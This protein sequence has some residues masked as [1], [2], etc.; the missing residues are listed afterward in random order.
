MK[1][2]VST[3][4]A[5]KIDDFTGFIG[6]AEDCEGDIWLCFKQGAC[7]VFDDSSFDLHDKEEI[8]KLHGPFTKFTG[9]V[10]ISN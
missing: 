1:V 4:T 7:M 9:S 10:T 2:E 5:K 8:L 3:T 6:L